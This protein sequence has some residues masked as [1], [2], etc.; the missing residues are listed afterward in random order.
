MEVG[1]LYNGKIE[2][3]KN[4]TVEFRVDNLPSGLLLVRMQS[5]GQVE[6]VKLVVKK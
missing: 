3:N 2:A 6:T 4:V 1:E 5:Q